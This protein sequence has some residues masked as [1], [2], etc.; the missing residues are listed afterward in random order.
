VEYSS[1]AINGAINGTNNDNNG[2]DQQQR[3]SSAASVRR[4]CLMVVINF[5]G[6]HSLALTESFCP[7]QMEFVVMLGYMH[8][9][10][11]VLLIG[12]DGFIPLVTKKSNSEG[13]EDTT[14][15]CQ[16]AATDSSP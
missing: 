1:G 16:L 10:T 14:P 5:R 6:L 15:C 7:G 2:C 11:N 9:A 3:R 8:V 13:K 4:E 12:C